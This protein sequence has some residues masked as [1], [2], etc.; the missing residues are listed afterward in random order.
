MK[1]SSI[2]EAIASTRTRLS[3][4]PT[5]RYIRVRKIDK[6]KEAR[7]PL[8]ELAKISE[9]VKRSATNTVIKK[10]GITPKVPG[11]TK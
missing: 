2:Q 1:Y 3:Q 7:R 9:K 4:F 10:S 11:S 8:L 5:P 6:A